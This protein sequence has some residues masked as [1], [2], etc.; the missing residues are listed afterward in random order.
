MKKQY[1]YVALLVLA[2]AVC[3]YLQVHLQEQHRKKTLAFRQRDTEA[4]E[5]MAACQLV[6]VQAVLAPQPEPPQRQPVGF[7]PQGAN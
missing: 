6:Y 2:V 4:W 3:L 7:Q 5:L 1:V